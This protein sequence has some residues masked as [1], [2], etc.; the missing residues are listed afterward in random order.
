MQKRCDRNRKR[1]KRRAIYCPEHGCYLNSMSQKYGL[2]AERAGQLQQRG[3]KRLDALMLVAAKTAIP[4]DGEW[5]EAFWCDECQQT[6]WYHVCKGD[7]TYEL[8]VAPPE[9]WQQATGVINPHRNPSVG[10][11]TS[12]NARMLRY[13]TIENFRFMY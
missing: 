12:R 10:E 1:S 2:F 13:R 5:L 8:S 9:L 6:K 3:I 11:F 4:L 7:S